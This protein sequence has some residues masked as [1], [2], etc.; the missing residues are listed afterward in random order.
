VRLRAGTAVGY[1][2]TFVILGP[3]PSSSAGQR[4]E[5]A[6]SPS[7]SL[8]KPKRSEGASRGSMPECGGRHRWCGDTRLFYILIVLPPL[9]RHGSSGLHLA[10]LGFARG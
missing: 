4:S 5:A 1:L 2:S 8:A 10:T 9:L 7:S 6:L 3:P